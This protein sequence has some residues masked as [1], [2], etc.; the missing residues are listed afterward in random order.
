LLFGF[1]P[2]APKFWGPIPFF[3]LFLF[4]FY[5]YAV[6]FTKGLTINV[7]LPPEPL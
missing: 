6:I 2:I 3:I 4:L 1:I 5:E 7:L